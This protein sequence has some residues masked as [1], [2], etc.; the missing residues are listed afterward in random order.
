MAEML[1]GMAGSLIVFAGFALGY[2][3]GVHSAKREQPKVIAEEKAE[4]EG[5]KIP[6]SQQFE[7]L[8]T[9]SGRADR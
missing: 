8:M 9:Y 7:N 6:V 2:G 3:I 1:V 5:E 4:T